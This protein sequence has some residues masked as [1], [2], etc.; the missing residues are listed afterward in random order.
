MLKQRV[1]SAI[2]FVPLF[3]GI[4][5]LGGKAFDLFLVLVLAFAGYEYTRM[6]ASAGYQVSRLLVIG[7]ILAVT[8]LRSFGNISVD[9]L[10]LTTILAVFGAFA[11]WKYEHG[12]Q[13]AFQG[14]TLQFFGVFYIGVLGAYGITL[15]HSG[16]DGNLWVLV[17]I[18]L[19]W[20]V[21]A[22]AYFFGTHFGKRIVL[23]RL[24]PKKTLEGFLGGT[25]VGVISGGLIGLIF[26][27]IM[28]ELG[29]LKGAF[30][31]LILGLLAFFGDA[32]MSLLKRTMEV[33]DT[34]TL[35]PGH[36]GVLDRLDSMLWA[37]AAGTYFAIFIG[38]L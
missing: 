24:S 20:L 17:T 26:S 2:V 14:L 8:V 16:P 32:L 7:S 19:V 33:K 37:M 13:Q 1:L 10:A 29:A 9:F 12:D 6:M 36:G 25:L 31:G 28:P 38:P 3:L 5:Y 30:L 23:P 21:D 4:A 15:N 34:G 22:G 27:G 18:G 35:L 11:L